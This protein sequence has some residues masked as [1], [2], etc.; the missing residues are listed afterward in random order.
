M[1]D[2]LRSRTEVIVGRLGLAD[3]DVGGSGRNE[4]DVV[5]ARLEVVCGVQALDRVAGGIVAS[6]L[7]AHV[8]LGRGTQHLVAANGLKESNWILIQR[9]L[10]VG[11]A[12]TDQT[13]SID[14]DV[15]ALI[16]AECTVDDTTSVPV[17]EAFA[18]RHAV[19]FALVGGPRVRHPPVD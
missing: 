14:A 3:D 8:L 16:V 13:L 10:S 1:I 15:G 17:I 5:V 18:A 4:Q 19:Q 2:C 11:G 12:T 6:A 7:A 9:H